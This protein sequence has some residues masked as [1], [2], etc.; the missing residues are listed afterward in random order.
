MI[1]SISVQYIYIYILDMYLV[2]LC[3]GLYFW[4]VFLLMDR[5]LPGSSTTLDVF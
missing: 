4:R 2:V 5:K 1:S 3:V